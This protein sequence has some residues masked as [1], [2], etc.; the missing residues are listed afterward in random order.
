MLYTFILMP[1][2]LKLCCIVTHPS[3]HDSVPEAS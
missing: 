3:A 2:R 1:L